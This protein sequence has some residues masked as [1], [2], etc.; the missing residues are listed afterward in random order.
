MGDSQKQAK[1]SVSFL[2][3]DEANINDTLAL[4][5]ISSL[6][7]SGSSSPLYKA[8][9]ASNIGSDYCANS[10]YDTASKIGS[11]S[12]GAQGVKN[13]DISKIEGIVMNTLEQVHQIGFEKKHIDAIL[14]QL[15]LSLKHVN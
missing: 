6:L 12:L 9:I 7:T 3:T 8:L 15:E 11:I 13:D 14:H 5:I 10:G 4:K 2:C 1:V